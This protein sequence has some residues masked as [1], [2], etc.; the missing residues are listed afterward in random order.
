MPRENKDSS[1][2]FRVT[3]KQKKLIEQKAKEFNFNSMSEY[4]KFVA[5]NS[6]LV[7]EAK[8]SRNA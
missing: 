2:H 5:I 4:L 1:I 6:H 7:L 3:S 8:G